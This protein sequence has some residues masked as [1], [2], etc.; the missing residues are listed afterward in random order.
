LGN[1]AMIAEEGKTVESE[2]IHYA[3]DRLLEARP[4]A[5]ATPDWEGRYKLMRRFLVSG[6]DY[7]PMLLMKANTEQDCDEAC[8]ALIATDGTGDKK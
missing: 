5:R 3:V 1:P 7:A 4:S 6:E 8:D 2:L